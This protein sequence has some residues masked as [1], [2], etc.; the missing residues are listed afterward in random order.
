MAQPKKFSPMRFTAA[1]EESAVAGALA[2]VGAAR[3][4]IDYD[5]LNQNV[6]G[7]T[8]RIRLRDES[9]PKPAPEPETVEIEEDEAPLHIDSMHE[10]D[11]AEDDIETGEDEVTDESYDFIALDTQDAG[12]DL[13]ES[14]DDA[15]D[16]AGED[17]IESDDNEEAGD[18]LDYDAEL[19]IDSDEYDVGDEQDETEEDEAE[20]PAREIDPAV[21][22]RALSL[23]TTFLEKLGLDAEVVPGEEGNAEFI[24]LIIEG[25][26]VG[27]LIGKHGATLQSFQYL[28]NATLNNDR[29]LETEGVRVTVDAG[30]YR[31][32]RQ[33]SLETL[34][35]G[36]AQ[37]A[38]REG[39]P[40]RLEPMPA[41]ERRI[42]HN[43]LQ[44]EPGIVT[45]SE[46]REPHRCVVVAPG[47]NT[48]SSGNG[49]GNRSSGARG[50]GGYTRGRGGRGR[51]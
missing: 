2:L 3:D 47:R 31:A 29:E 48:E 16:D 18:E 40:I 17:L 21:Q 8:V 20:E 15:S 50:M 45:Q 33:S 43:F 11:E 41:N 12:E 44:T 23:A 38:R 28:L 1:T 22:Q 30:N 39:G 5:V 19:E 4:E 46:G 14:D 27:I 35:R 25:E 51:R 32:R 42:V 34:A 6:K 36:A 9:A 13:I 49:G 24:P 26:D 10:D 7:V 37:R